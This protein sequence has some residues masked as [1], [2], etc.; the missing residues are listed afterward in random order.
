MEL[1]VMCSSSSSCC[2]CG[3]VGALLGAW[4]SSR[5]RLDRTEPKPAERKKC[6]QFIASLSRLMVVCSR[7]ST[8]LANAGG[9]MA[10]VLARI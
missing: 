7:L 1:I 5:F 2:I 6:L 4:W 9:S 3:D 10:A 8:F